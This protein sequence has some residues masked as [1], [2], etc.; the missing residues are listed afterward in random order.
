MNTLTKIS[1]II[2]SAVLCLTAC[3]SGK[4][5]KSATSAKMLQGEWKILSTKD[6]AFP[7]ESEAFF[8]F[9]LN[10]G[11]FY[12][13]AGCNRLTAS[14]T[15]DDAGSLKLSYLGST[16]MMCPDMQQEDAVL[17]TLPMVSR[18]SFSGDTLTLSDQSSA[19]LIILKKR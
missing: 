17:S 12:G 16:R 7:A 5:T 11:R 10:E 19:K 13:S 1:A 9:A 14:F 8:G 3:S 4:V 6:L 18:F 2:A 15:A